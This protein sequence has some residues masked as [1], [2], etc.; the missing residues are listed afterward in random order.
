MDAS[1]AQLVQGIDWARQGTHQ[2]GVQKYTERL[3]NS[4]YIQGG[5]DL[6]HQK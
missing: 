3:N 2:E 1:T 4:P 5:P 6:V